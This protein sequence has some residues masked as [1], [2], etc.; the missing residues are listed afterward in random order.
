MTWTILYIIAGLFLL[1]HWK[2]PN[3]VWGGA[4]IAAIIG[5]IIIIF[6]DNGWILVLNS[7]SLGAIIG[8]IFE[9]IH[10]L[11]KKKK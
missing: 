6:S 10:V 8:G 2:G 1:Y 9:T 4:T 11:T 5:I 7:A 3:A